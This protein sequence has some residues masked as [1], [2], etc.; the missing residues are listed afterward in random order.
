MITILDKHTE[1]EVMGK[2]HMWQE[3][4][5]PVP[6]QQLKGRDSR[7]DSGAPLSSVNC[8]V[9]FYQ[10]LLLRTSVPAQRGTLQSES[11]TLQN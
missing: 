7:S 3:H 5:L 11:L 2:A 1:S 9:R 10:Q 8:L 6:G 4:Q